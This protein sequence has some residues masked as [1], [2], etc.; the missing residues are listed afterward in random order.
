MRRIVP[1]AHAISLRARTRIR[2]PRRPALTHIEATTDPLRAPA[3]EAD[4][5][6]RGFYFA[7]GAGGGSATVVVFLSPH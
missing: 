2:I 4:G 1:Y 3:A 7:D 6:G 5:E